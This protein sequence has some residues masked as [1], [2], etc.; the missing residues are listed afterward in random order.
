MRTLSYLVAFTVAISG[1]VAV[2]PSASATAP[3]TP[4]RGK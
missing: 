2:E 3:D 4:A 1:L